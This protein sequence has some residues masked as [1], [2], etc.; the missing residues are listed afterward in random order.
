MININVHKIGE[1]AYQV[2]VSDGETGSWYRVL[3]PE[4]FYQRLTAGRI[5]KIK[6]VEAAFR[7]LL[8][9]RSKE[10]IHSRFDLPEIQEVFP[11]FKKEFDQYAQLALS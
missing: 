10:T 6:C 5:S 4:G 1:L 2:S 7:F 11:D 3:V 9:R 8:D